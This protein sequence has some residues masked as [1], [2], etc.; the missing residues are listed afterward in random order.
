MHQPVGRF[1]QSLPLKFELAGEPSV[2]TVEQRD[3]PET[4]LFDPEV[5]GSADAGGW[6]VEI[7]D[8]RK[9]ASN[10]LA[11]GINGAIIDDD[12]LQRTTGLAENGTEGA[13]EEMGP[14]T[15]GDDHRDR[16]LHL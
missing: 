3:P 2:I 1:P 15:G 9:T 6:L 16:Q 12:D 8:F 14:V 10:K 13:R 11:G 4:G 5:A 7:T